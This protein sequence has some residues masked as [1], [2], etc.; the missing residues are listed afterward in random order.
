MMTYDGSIGQ[1]LLGWF[2]FGSVLLTVS[3]VG[4]SVVI[5]VVRKNVVVKM[6]KL[7]DRMNDDSEEE[8]ETV[9]ESYQG[10]PSHA[11]PGLL[12]GQ[13]ADSAKKYFVEEKLKVHIQ[14]KAQGWVFQ[15]VADEAPIRYGVVATSQEVLVKRLKSHKLVPVKVYADDLEDD[16]TGELVGH[17]RVPR[18]IDAREFGEEYQHEGFNHFKDVDDGK[19]KMRFGVMSRQEPRT[20][21]RSKK[22]TYVNRTTE[23]DDDNE[24]K[25]MKKRLGVVKEV[26]SSVQYLL[27]NQGQEEK[28]EVKKKEDYLD[29]FLEGEQAEYENADDWLDDDQDANPFAL[30]HDG[31]NFK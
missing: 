4:L 14:G 23:D 21:L 12:V 26:K 1:E 13:D 22:H 10:H 9:V 3:V 20:Y 18:V 16:G 29:L 17:A 7:L 6:Q 19:G 28:V 15:D 8:V 30:H 11:G 25:K 2:R 27:D 5:V 31:A 24:K